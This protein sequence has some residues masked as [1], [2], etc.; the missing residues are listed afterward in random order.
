MYTCGYG[1]TLYCYDTKTGKTLFTYGNGGSG[2]STNSGFNTVYGVFPLLIG[3][4][5][6]GKIY[7]FTSEHSPNTP[8]YEGALVRCV[9]AM[10]GKELWTLDDWSHSNTM[11]VADG[12]IVYN[13]LYDMR[14]YCVGKGPSATTVSAPQTVIPLGQKVLITG[15]VT[16][17]SSGAKGTP[18]ISDESMG[19]WMAYIYMQKPKPANAGG[20][21]VHITAT[22]PNNN[23]QD[24]G[25]ATTDTKGNYAIMWNPPVEGQYKVIATFE[26]T[27][28]Y[29]DSDATTYFGVGPAETVRPVVTPTPTQNPT[30]T[31]PP[32]IAPTTP[33]PTTSETPSPAV[34][35]PAS[36]TLTTTY[37]AITAAVIVI[38][39]IAAALI[40]RKRR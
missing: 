16:D 23:F 26:G 33:A 19:D 6:D 14:I 32:T 37:A 38:V 40:L 8:L 25:T 4:V 11:A 18:A 21:K 28:S 10:S 22:D 7:L 5:A 27:K 30:P 12:Y 1:G 29:G 3:A 13:N 36:G 31:V 17:Q 15:S 39:A 24:I 35:P 2:N 9:D 20:V 34:T